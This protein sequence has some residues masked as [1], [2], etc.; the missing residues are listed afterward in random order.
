MLYCWDRRS[1][2]CTSQ[3]VCEQP[4]T[5]LAQVDDS[6]VW[7]GDLGAHVTIYAISLTV[8]GVNRSKAVRFH[9]PHGTPTCLLA[10]RGAVW[11]GTTK[12]TVAVYEAAPTAQAS[13]QIEA[14]GAAPPTLRGREL[15][16]DGAR[17]QVYQLVRVADTVLAAAKSPLVNVWTLDG[18]LVRVIETQHEFSVLAICA[19]GANFFATSGWDKRICVWHSRSFERLHDTANAHDDVVTSLALVPECYDAPLWSAS[20]DR[21]VKMWQFGV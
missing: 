20:V 8:Y 7:C 13:V 11:V 12:G 10:V 16:I 9:V 15:R 6:M 19:L 3:V 2:A 1:V 4:I 5:C 14:G 17:Q 21:S 18:D